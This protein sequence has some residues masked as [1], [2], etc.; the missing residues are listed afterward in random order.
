MNAVILVACC[1]PKMNKQAP[2]ANLY[3]SPLFKKARSYAEKRG[4][5]FI[6]SAL[7][8]LLDPTAVIAPYDLTLKKLPAQKRRE[9]GEMVREQ[10]GKAGLIGVPLVA[11]AGADYVKPLMDAGLT[12]TQP[13]KGYRIGKQLQWLTRENASPTAG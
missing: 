9:W 11:L 13:M 7:Y 5:W 1:G 8:G 12:V 6:L 2:A 10:M 3:I 4:R